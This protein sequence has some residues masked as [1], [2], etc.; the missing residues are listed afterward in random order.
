MKLQAQSPTAPATNATILVVEDGS[1]EREAVVRLLQMEGYQVV[2]A[3]DV[4]AALRYI[5][6]P[7]D[8]V[9]TDLRMGSRSGVDLLQAWRERH[10]TTPFFIMTAFGD[11]ESAVRAMKLG[12][13]DYIA[14]PIDPA[15]F[16]QSVRSCLNER[17][18]VP[19][20]RDEN[21]VKVEQLLGMSPGM[22]RVREQV[23]RAAAADS[24]VLIHGESGTGK[25]LAARA[26]HA[27]S[28][29]S[30]EPLVIVNVA[31]IPETLIESELFGHVQ[32]AFSAVTTEREGRFTAAAG[33]MLFIDEVGDLPQ[34]SQAKLLRLLE[35]HVLQRIGEDKDYPIDVRVVVATSRD[36]RQMV[37][38]STFRL[39][40]L[41]RMNVV[42]I[43]IPPLRERPEDVPLLLDHY[44][45][46]VAAALNKP[47]PTMSNE[48]FAYL[49]NHRW[50]GNVREL[51]NC[52]E[53]MVVSAQ[54]DRLTIQDLPAM[55]MATPPESSAVYKESQLES[56]A[57][58]L[59]LR[60]LN[61]CDGSR[62]RTAEQLGISV[63]T[64]QRRLKAW[65][66]TT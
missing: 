19:R 38:R 65:N 16:L 5:A 58:S 39:D 63:R 34:Q 44:V 66:M 13:R 8:M 26:I 29:R 20:L 54:S 62:S 17:V 37:D 46:A 28:S 21:E 24:P 61:E 43:E 64:L 40:L 3:G 45:R 42:S 27:H 32:G 36:L 56:F 6:H 7:I 15:R 60:T 51:R 30:A 9:V 50:S 35:S 14:K 25:E 1:L 22:H 4:D 33:G 2:A 12:A 49:C 53:S 57:K 11:A 59:I 10:P 52:M 47:V 41:Y 48:L 55:I 18:A 31:A 23:L